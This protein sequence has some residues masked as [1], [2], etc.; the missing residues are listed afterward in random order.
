MISTS[1]SLPPEFDKAFKVLSKRIHSSFNCPTVKLT[2]TLWMETGA[3]ESIK[4]KLKI[5]EIPSGSEWRWNQ[6]KR[7]YTL[8]CEKSGILIEL[9]KLVPRKSARS[10]LTTLPKY[11]LWQ[12]S[13][14]S[15]TNPMTVFWCEKGADFNEPKEDLQLQDYSFLAEFMD[16]SE[17]K[18][19][20]PELLPQTNN[21]CVP[22]PLIHEEF[23][24]ALLDFLLA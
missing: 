21:T 20:W 19:L 23:D 18:Q 3:I 15:K 10:T 16:A 11:K 17:A 6:A 1:C 5:R 12:A 4:K 7:R 22:T 24:V 8:S 9:T 14:L 13:V 2:D